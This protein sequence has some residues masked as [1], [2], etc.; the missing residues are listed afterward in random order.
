MGNDS[1]TENGN[2]EIVVELNSR[3]IAQNWFRNMRVRATPWKTLLLN[4]ENT[5]LSTAFAPLASVGGSESSVK[6]GGSHKLE[7]AVKLSGFLSAIVNAAG[8]PKEP[9]SELAKSDGLKHLEESAK[10]VSFL[11]FVGSVFGLL[12]LG[13]GA[14]ETYARNREDRRSA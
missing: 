5:P 12:G 8:N 4:K 11:P 7:Q 3:D 6:I 10:R 13:L 2:Q 1:K 14:I 9:L